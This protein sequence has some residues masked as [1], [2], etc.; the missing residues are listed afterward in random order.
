MSRW[1]KWSFHVLLI[2]VS[3]TGVL[4]FWMKY[5]MEDGDPFS[6]VNHP[7]QSF[8]LDLH[9]MVSPLLIFVVAG[10]IYSHV[11]QKLS[12]R[13]NS[14]RRSGLAALICF[15]PMVL[16]GYL[17]QVAADTWVYR[18]SLLL[19]LLTGGIFLITYLLHQVISI[20]LLRKNHVKQEQKVRIANAA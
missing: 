14:N 10:V 8:V 5:L 19:H 15:A 3:V 4:Y 1:E 12:D 9:I 17:L 20:H 13:T 7:L 16:S 18:V 11:I 2:L 6:L